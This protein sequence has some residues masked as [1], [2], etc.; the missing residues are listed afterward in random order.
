MAWNEPMP[1]EGSDCGRGRFRHGGGARGCSPGHHVTLY[2][3]AKELGGHLLEASVPSFK[4]MSPPV[5]VFKGELGTLEM[6]IQLG[7][8]VTPDT[9]RK[10]KPGVVI[11][12]AGSKPFI[13]EI[14]GIGRDNVATAT[15]LLLGKKKVKDSAVV[16][17]GGLI[18]CE[19]A[20]WLAQQGKKVTLVEMLEDLMIAGIP[21]RT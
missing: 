14:P 18:G 9:I 16:V 21:L 17:G 4:R 7:V 1:P 13:P 5:R 8:E 19:T 20:L 12:A 15:D 10:E 11:I 6:D 2:D 3:R